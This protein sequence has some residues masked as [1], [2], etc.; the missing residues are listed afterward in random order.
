VEPEQVQ[1]LVLHQEVKPE[2]QVQL[3]LPAQLVQPEL[4]EQQ[5]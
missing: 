5:A 2:Q 1:E 3:A 4:L